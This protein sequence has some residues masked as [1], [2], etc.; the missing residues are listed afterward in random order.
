MIKWD[1]KL[2]DPIE[3]FDPNLSYEITGYRPITEDKGLDFDVTPFIEAGQI[4]IKTNRYCP[5]PAGTK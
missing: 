5:H 2:G 4:K 3:Y 1:V